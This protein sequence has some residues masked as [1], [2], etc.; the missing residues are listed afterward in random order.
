MTIRVPLVLLLLLLASSGAASGDADSER[1]VVLVLLGGGVTAEE[2]ADDA[3]MPWLARVL[4]RS[5]APVKSSA[6][7][8]SSKLMVQ[9]SSI[10]IFVNR[11]WVFH[12]TIQ[13]DQD[14]AVAF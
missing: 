12:A 5:V 3:R 10:P 1:P 4:A 11:S 2:M 9:V 14:I 6:M 13:V 7:H 8:P